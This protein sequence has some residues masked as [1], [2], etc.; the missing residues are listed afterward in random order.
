M[1]QPLGMTK[2][3]CDP[4]GYFRLENREERDTSPDA[5]ARAAGERL[6]GACFG[7]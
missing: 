6:W 2:K 4:Q 5:A 3:G 7:F 1:G